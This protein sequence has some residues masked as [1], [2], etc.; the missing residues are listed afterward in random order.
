MQL[1]LRLRIFRAHRQ[2]RG[3]SQRHAGPNAASGLRIPIRRGGL[4]EART[5][6]RDLR[7]AGSVQLVEHDRSIAK[8][9]ASG[10]QSLRQFR[11][12]GSRKRTSTDFT[13]VST[14]RWRGSPFNAGS[15]DSQC[16]RNNEPSRKR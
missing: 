2:G 11:V 6:S 3:F 4:S 9:F 16:S 7:A 8:L 5:I 14:T 10:G 13:R 15:I 1:G 12:T